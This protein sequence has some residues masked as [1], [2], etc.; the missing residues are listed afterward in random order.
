MATSTPR[1]APEHE[2]RGSFRVQRWVFAFGCG[3]FVLV[4]Y[5]LL[6]EWN[7]A[8]FAAGT[9]PIR[10]DTWLDR[11]IPFVPG[12]FWV[13][14]CYYLVAI[15]PAWLA[16]RWSDFKPMATSYGVATAL[17]WVA[18]IA[19]PVRMIPPPL[20]CSGLTCQVL[21]RFID[22]DGGVNVFPS[23]HVAHSMLA[24]LFHL[25]HRSAARWLVAAGALGV[26][27][28][29]VLIRQ[30]Y[31]VDIP[32]GLAVAAVGWIAGLRVAEPREAGLRVARGSRCA[33]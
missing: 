10:L 7:L 26:T 25:R 1:T 9:H 5:V 8:R 17:A 2:A 15:S 29:T 13:Y 6:A 21:L 30:H 33:S 27:A 32:A 4:G 11:H 12:A 24:A 28:S 20:A 14:V 18:W 3:I 23:M 19:L 22:A 16:R 31:V